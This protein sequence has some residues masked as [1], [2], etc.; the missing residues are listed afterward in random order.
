MGLKQRGW[1]IMK[2]DS[3]GIDCSW[4][5]RT[6]AK[7]RFDTTKGDLFSYLNHY[8]IALHLFTII[9]I[10]SFVRSFFS[11]CLSLS[12]SLSFF[13]SCF[14]TQV[15]VKVEIFG[16]VASLLLVSSYFIT[17]HSTYHY[18]S[19][20]F[21]F[22][23]TRKWKI[24]CFS[25]ALFYKFSFSLPF[26]FTVCNR[27]FITQNPPKTFSTISLCLSTEVPLKKL[28]SSPKT[29]ISKKNWD[30]SWDPANAE[31]QSERISKNS[32]KQIL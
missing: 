30:F 6:V 16:S 9:S 7:N 21:W 2:F 14:F 28:Q 26:T 19:I 11:L 4:R 12:R 13:F 31:C 18:S 22:L 3:R 15:L 24:L 29:G 20:Y 17:L 23:I 27:F 5:R 25:N 10:R 32:T 1:K 8:T